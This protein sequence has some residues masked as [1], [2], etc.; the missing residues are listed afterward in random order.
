MREAQLDKSQ[1]M[2]IDACWTGPK[3]GILYMPVLTPDLN[4]VS[5]SGLAPSGTPNF[6]ATCYFQSIHQDIGLVAYYID[7][8]C[9]TFE[10]HV[11]D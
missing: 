8:G 7:Y 10:L 6:I 1:S 4:T 5:R 3:K 9:S 11:I 2:V